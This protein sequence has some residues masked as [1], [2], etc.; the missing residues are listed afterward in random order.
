MLRSQGLVLETAVSQTLKTSYFLSGKAAADT[1]GNFPWE[2][3]GRAKIWNILQ[4]YGVGDAV[5]SWEP[6]GDT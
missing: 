5:W 1:N 6:W 3:A 2:N 4:S